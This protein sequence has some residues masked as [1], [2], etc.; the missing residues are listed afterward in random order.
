MPAAWG[1]WHVT[2]MSCPAIPLW[3][4]RWGDVSWV[5]RGSRNATRVGGMSLGPACMPRNPPV[6]EGAMGCTLPLPCAGLR[7][8][9]VVHAN[10]SAGTQLPPA[11]LPRNVPARVRGARP[12]AESNNIQQRQKSCNV[13]SK[14]DEEYNKKL[15]VVRQGCTSLPKE[16]LPARL[17]RSRQSLQL[18][19]LNRVTEMLDK[20][21]VVLP[22]NILPVAMPVVIWLFSS[23]L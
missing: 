6:G 15:E 23:A 20:R 7:C 12:L 10:S 8:A 13:N 9:V 16:H 3:V 11:L 4:C 5:R 21:F 18:R 17:A 2:G 1:A 19:L 14:E 22:P